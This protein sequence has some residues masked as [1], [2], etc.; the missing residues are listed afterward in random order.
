[1]AVTLIIIKQMSEKRKE[2]HIR[3]LRCTIN[4]QKYEICKLT[5]DLEKRESLVTQLSKRLN[6]VTEEL[7]TTRN[8]MHCAAE[9]RNEAEKQLHKAQKE[10]KML[11]I[12]VKEFFQISQL[13]KMF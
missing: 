8:D 10:L 5:S 12:P 9:E 3:T 6:E 4:E 11:K 13:L 7:N 2:E 1:M